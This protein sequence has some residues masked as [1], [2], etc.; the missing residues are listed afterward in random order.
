M[1]HWF[2][3]DKGWFGVK[4]EHRR[5]ILELLNNISYESEIERIEDR[6]LPSLDK[7]KEFADNWFIAYEI[8]TVKPVEE[9]V[10][11]EGMREKEE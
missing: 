4:L 1:D 6:P 2:K 7:V 8:T 10:K 11:E 5:R 3:C 9:E